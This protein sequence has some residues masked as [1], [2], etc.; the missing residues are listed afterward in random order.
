M[1]T[2]RYIKAIIYLTAT[3]FT[4][5]LYVHHEALKSAWLQ[6]LS[7][8]IVVVLYAV[9]AFDLWLWKLPLLHSWFVKRPVVAGT[10]K[11][12]IRSNWVDPATGASLGPVEGY[13]VIRQTLSTLSLRLLTAESSSELVGTEIV[14]ASD[15]LYCIS[16]VYRNE[17]RFGVRERSPIH[18]GAV[19]LRIIDEPSQKLLGHYWTDR[20]TG[21][22]MELT[23]RQHKIV[24]TFESARAYYTE[25]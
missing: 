4:V 15:G 13:A 7:T 22:E 21:G 1:T 18:Y 6:Y 2:E 8:A 9:M 19:W 14:C 3:V 25:Q 11:V 17:P 24:Q 12:E 10:W 23:S 16:G 5:I 20:K